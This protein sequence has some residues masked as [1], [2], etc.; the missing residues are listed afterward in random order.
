MQSLRL[1]RMCNFRYTMLQKIDA[2]S[3]YKDRYLDQYLLLHKKE[4]QIRSTSLKVQCTWAFRLEVNLG[5]GY[6]LVIVL[7]EYKH[8]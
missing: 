7:C 1:H 6:P 3:N 4:M 5:L 8:M 2:K